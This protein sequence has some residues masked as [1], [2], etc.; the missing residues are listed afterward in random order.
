MAAIF[1][2]LKFKA[3]TN[4]I[5]DFVNEGKFEVRYIIKH[6]I[7]FPFAYMKEHICSFS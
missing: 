1:Q 5:S 3:A 4:R 6:K 7:S 2:V